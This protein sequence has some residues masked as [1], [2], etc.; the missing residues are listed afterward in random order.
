MFAAMLVTYREGL[1]AALIIA[2]LISLLG[3]FGNRRLTRAVWAGSIAAVAVSVISG[4]IAFLLVGEA[5]EEAG[6]VFE[7]LVVFAAVLLVT[8]LVIWMR[9]NGRDAHARLVR[10]TQDAARTASPLALGALAFAAVGREGL[11]TVLFLLAG[12]G[13]EG[14][15][16]VVTGGLAGLSLAIITGIIFYRGS[17]KVDLSALFRFTGVLLIVFAAG[18]LGHSL[19]ELGETGLWPSFFGPVWDTSNLMGD[20]SGLGS[21][22]KSL[23][24]YDASPSLAQIAGYWTYLAVMMWLFLR[25]ARAV[26]AAR[27]ASENAA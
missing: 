14:S 6:E 7:I 26:R 23:V 15:F 24:G 16:G 19:G 20:K 18:F 12:A 17:L 4:V 11:E 5:A 8:Y 21:V 2:V 3:R 13:N 1:E 9:N 22:L 27:Q 25:P 10:R